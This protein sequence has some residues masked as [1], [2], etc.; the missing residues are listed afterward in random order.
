MAKARA[1]AMRCGFPLPGRVPKAPGQRPPRPWRALTRPPGQALAQALWF[2]TI[3]GAALDV[4]ERE[5]AIPEELM[6]AD[7]L[8]MLPHLGSATDR[9]REAMGFKVMENLTAFFAGQ[10][11]PDRVV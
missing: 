8:V 2:G 4:F 3:A 9:T 6:G 10:P 5:P 11:L 7:N 1:F